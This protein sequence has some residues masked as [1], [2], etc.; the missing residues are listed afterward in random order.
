MLGAKTGSILIFQVSTKKDW[1]ERSQLNKHKIN[2]KYNSVLQKY[3]QEILESS[4][5]TNG[6]KYNTKVLIRN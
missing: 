6:K 3:L 1:S 4:Y 2:S 5:P